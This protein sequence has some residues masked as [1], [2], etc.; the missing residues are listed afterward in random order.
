MKT[1]YVLVFG[2][3]MGDRKK[4]IDL[5]I[6]YLQKEIQF[7]KHSSV[8]ETD[9][10]L[11]HETFKNMNVFLNQGALIESALHPPELLGLCKKVEKLVGRKKRERYGRR[12]IDIDIVWWSQGD[13]HTADLTIPHEFN[14]GRYWVRKILNELVVIE[15]NT[16]GNNMEKNNAEQKKMYEGKPIHTIH[17]FTKKKSSGEKITMLTCYDYT[18]AKLLARTSLDTILVGDSMANVMQGADTTLSVTVDD[19]IYHSKAV[20]R[21]FPDIFITAD[22]PFLSYQVSD[23]QA[24]QNGGRILKESGVNA[25]KIE[26]GENFASTVKALTRASIPV[27]G[28][29]GLTPQSYHSLG[30][31]KVQARDQLAQDFLLGDARVLQDAGA[32]AL[33]LEMVPHELAKL[34]ATELDIPV[35]GIGAGNDCDGQV[36]VFQD[37]LGMNTDF[38]PK[39][40]RRF[41][42]LSKQIP[43]AVESYCEHVRGG[44]FP[45][46]DEQY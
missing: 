17:D 38:S 22:M 8:L 45:S 13:Y 2:S 44:T 7:I 41:A 46:Q 42:N 21:G 43:E 31:Y 6:Q 1:R 15:N 12:E 34:V 25:V 3:N 11:S 18:S 5:A 23:E 27:M 4:N 29:L 26:G 36:L 39:F 32:F 30:G 35:I 19:V 33:V 16:K 14:G 20:R 10:I 24:V 28:H 40:V 37:M 9:A